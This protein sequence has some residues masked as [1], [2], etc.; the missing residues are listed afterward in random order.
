MSCS[1]SRLENFSK[2]RHQHETPHSKHIKSADV[3]WTEK[4]GYSKKILL[5]P[6]LLGKPGLLVQSLRIKPNEVCAPHLHKKQTEIFYFLNTN[7]EFSINGK[8]VDLSAGDAFVVEPNDVHTV[9]ND[10]DEDF[11]YVA[12]KFDWVEN[13][14]FEA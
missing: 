7:G 14:Y 2:N 6:E 1:R 11:L 5:T 4:P 12:F 9:R 8:K 13:D 3:P 10:S